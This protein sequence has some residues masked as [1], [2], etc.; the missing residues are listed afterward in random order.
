MTIAYRIRAPL[1]PRRANDN[2]RNHSSSLFRTYKA[3]HDVLAVDMH[4]LQKIN[5]L[6][7]GARRYQRDNYEWISFEC[8]CDKISFRTDKCVKQTCRMR[9]M[10][11]LLRGDKPADVY[12]NVPQTS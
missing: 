6:V 2:G 11:R 4:T 5:N 1:R 7:E 10:W 12:A 3:Q 9:R 8:F